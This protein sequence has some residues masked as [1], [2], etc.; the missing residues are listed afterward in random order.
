MSRLRNRAVERIGDAD[1]DA[2]DDA[3]RHELE[4]HKV[5]L[6]LQNNALMATRDELANALHRYRA[7]F[8]LSPV[9]L[10]VLDERGSVLEVNDAAARILRSSESELLGRPLAGW[11]HPADADFWHL[12]HRD[13]FGRRVPTRHHFRLNLH[14]KEPRT[15]QF[16]SVPTDDPDGPR[17]LTA[18][19]DLHPPGETSDDFAT[20]AEDDQ[21]TEDSASAEE[22]LHEQARRGRKLEAIGPL[23]AGIA[24]DF[25]NLLMGIRGVVDLASRKLPEGHSVRSHLDE[26]RSVATSGATITQQLRSLA[27]QTGGLP[28]TVDVDARV[29]GM[30]G[31]LRTVLGEDVTLELRLN[32]PES[33]LQVDPDEFEHMLLH[34]AVH[35]RDSMPTGGTL[36]FETKVWDEPPG[37][38]PG[39]FG[40]EPVLRI[41]VENSGLVDEAT[42]KPL[43]MVL[44][45]AEA[46]GG[47]CVT[48]SVEN[49]T[50][51][52]LWLPCVR[53]DVDI[54]EVIHEKRAIEP[55]TILVVEDDRLVRRTLRQYLESADHRV[56]EAASAEEAE[57]VARQ[58]DGKID[59]IVTDSVL[60]DGYG[61]DVATNVMEFAP[62]AGVLFVS[63][64]GFAKLVQDQRVPEYARF[65]QKPFDRKELLDDVADA[66]NAA[67]D[68]HD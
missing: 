15:A 45:S 30:R 61:L 6:E 38:V 34:L 57:R 53:E 23:A 67:R 29:S 55:A 56:V 39:E 46:L 50:T 2:S 14:D 37:E 12:H 25:N 33:R 31:L 22:E 48:T 52:D 10:L 13:S 65:L 64:H 51:V 11:I 28:K 18:I 59:L 42:T 7:L 63:A 66:I 62:S 43:A 9:A 47:T 44:E 17:L 21:D 35:G 40:D 41:R 32:A 20:T 1:A 26:I 49:T 58:F 3:T 4:V 27:T 16:I 54:R 36:R 60:A 68:Q 19:I 24:H 5:E 8:H